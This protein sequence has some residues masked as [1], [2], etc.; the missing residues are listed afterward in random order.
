MAL[1]LYDTL[2][3]AAVPFE[4]LDAPRVRMYTCGPTVH[5]YAHI[6]N[7]RTFLFEDLLRRVLESR[8]LDVK[9]VM[10]LTDVDDRIIEKATAAGTTI[11]EFTERYKK[12]F[13]EDL[14]TL[15]VEP[16]EEYPAATEHIDAMVELVERLRAGG[17]TYDTEDG[18]VY[19][20][21]ASFEPYGRLSGVDL[22][23]MRDGAR[24]DSD[25]YDKENPKDFALWK[26][27]RPGEE[28]WDTPLG[29]GRPGWHLECSAMSMAYLG[30]SFDI[31]TG[32]VDNIFPH[33]ENEIAQSEA[34]TGKPFARYW[35]HAEHLIVEGQ[36]MSK[37]LNN[38][39]TLRD[40]MERGH[41]PRAIRY[42]LLAS[43]YRSQLNFTF[44]GLGQ[45]AAA[46]SRLG[47][48]QARLESLNGGA[49]ESAS[50]SERT[51]QAVAAF[52]AALDDDLNSARALGVVFEWVRDIN[53]AIDEGVATTAD[54]PGLEAFLRHF[55]A[56]YDVLNPDPDEVDIDADIEA[57]VAEREQA[58]ESGDFAR[59]DAIRDEL[60]ARGVILEDTPD[61]VRVKR[62]P[63]TG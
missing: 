55:D 10:N 32:G 11:H 1:V 63:S 48:F 7:L 43:H 21:I 37:S 19:F 34:A 24:V 57:L 26:A 27:A 30:E 47:D 35:L 61:G 53:R 50:I 20:R 44:K 33:H 40:V 58:R 39:F 4:P 59:A 62:G 2:R 60:A 8:G 6:G 17:H 14:A 29:R 36:K 15:R 31:H 25:S 52:D 28:A 38:F 51:E 22:S 54:Q 23:G 12:A 3:R 42:L 5:D 16:A 45:A 41:R 46:I 56:V 13:F 49:G 18:S 9:Q